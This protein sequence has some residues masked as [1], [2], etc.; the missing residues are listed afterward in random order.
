MSFC[1]Q[2][3]A[4]ISSYSSLPLPTS[5]SSS[6]RATANLSRF[7][8]SPPNPV[9][10][11]LVAAGGGSRRRSHR[12]A[13]QADRRRH[14]YAAAEL[15]MATSAPPPSQVRSRTLDWAAAARN[16]VKTVTW[17]SDRRSKAKELSED[18]K[19]VKSQVVC[20]FLIILTVI[21]IKIFRIY[22]SELLLVMHRKVP[23]PIQYS[24]HC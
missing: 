23:H 11:P 20:S 4:Y 24:L 12:H 7:N 21:A 6:A 16:R 17:S 22:K 14:R 19:V 18:R 9:I 8:V 1:D 3:I 13:T 5:S 15:H 10:E 2:G